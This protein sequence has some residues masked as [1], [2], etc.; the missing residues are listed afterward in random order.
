MQTW[1]A[2]LLI[3]GVPVGLGAAVLTVP[4]FILIMIQ[5]DLGSALVLV[6]IMVGALFLGGAAQLSRRNHRRESQRHD[7]GDRHRT[8]Q[9]QRELAKQ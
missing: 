4:P 3:T 5:P 6:A 9:G 1:Q 2:L 7:P 8:G